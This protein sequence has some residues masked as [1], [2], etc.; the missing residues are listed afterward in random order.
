[1]GDLYGAGL[2]VSQDNGQTYEL[3]NTGLQNLFVGAL[4]AG[5]GSDSVVAG[6]DNGVFLSSGGA[7]WQRP[8]GFAEGVFSLFRHPD[9]SI[10]AGT[11][12]AGVWKSGDGGT[13]WSRASSGIV[14]P[15][16]TGLS[17]TAEGLTAFAATA[18]GPYISRNSGQDW[19]IYQTLGITFS[20]AIDIV[21]PL[22]VFLGGENGKLLYSSDGGQAFALMNK[23]L[24]TDG[25]TWIRVIPFHET[26]LITSAGALYVLDAGKSQWRLLFQRAGAQAYAMDADPRE[27]N[28]L[29]LAT[30]DGVYKSTDA[31]ANW[32]KLAG[33]TGPA[34][35][36]F[37]DIL[38]PGTFYA[39]GL[40]KVAR[41]TDRGESW[42]EFGTGL[43]QGPVTGV[44]KA[45][46]QVLAAVF[47]QGVYRTGAGGD[48]WQ[49][50]PVLPSQ[51][52]T[53]LTSA[54]NEPR[55]ILAG[56]TTDGIFRSTDG[57]A[58]WSRAENGLSL[59]VRGLGGDATGS[60]LYAG[61]LLGGLF[62][63]D[64]GGANWSSAG[65]RD[66]N[67]FDIKAHPVDPN[68]VYAGTSIGI[69][70]STDRGRTWTQVTQ[71][72]ATVTAAAVDPRDRGIIYTG[73]LAGR[74][75]RSLDGGRGWTIANQGL[76]PQS[77]EA[78]TV[79][80]R[81]GT[82]YAALDKSGVFRSRNQGRDW[83]RVS[84]LE[85]VRVLI[86]S[87][88]GVLY[89]GTRANGV[90]QVD[91]TGRW[92]SFAG[93]LPT[94]EIHSLAL[95]MSSPAALLAAHGNGVFRTTDGRNWQ[96]ANR[97]LASGV[98]GL[99]AD[100][101]RPGK[102]YAATSSGLFVTEDSGGRWAAVAG[103]LPRTE[104]TAV[105]VD[106]R[107][108]IVIA[109]GKDGRLWLSSDSGRSWRSSLEGADLAGRA[110][111]FGAGNE[112]LAGSLTRG[113]ARSNDGGAN[114]T[115][116]NAA[117][118]T[119]FACLALAVHPRNPSLVYAG[120]VGPGVLKSIDGG[121][122]W[123]GV[124]GG[125][126]GAQILSLAIDPANPDALFAGTA[127]RGVYATSNGGASWSALGVGIA[128]RTVTALLFDTRNG[129]S[130]YAGTEGGGVFRLD[131]PGR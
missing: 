85:D 66:R 17:I 101:S 89:A 87:P 92:I 33:Y 7:N 107:G 103:G 41:S 121:L 8:T 72:I 80:P 11:E 115:V 122:T 27:P 75:D 40:G 71:R 21:N 19:G 13:T 106:P 59:F 49:K 23:G 111:V 102:L 6:S 125:I 9:G 44:I 2:R 52:V 119:E 131:L 77:V 81:D 82:V 31:G 130:L 39:G 20:S 45:G 126:E 30:F 37:A 3:R 112:I 108:Q 16:I 57:G 18:A 12:R 74:L 29:L 91:E 104:M 51:G 32:S 113:L 38:E 93:N 50:A 26:Y 5:S 116:N 73:G 1:V 68:T 54:L 124:T 65:L 53:V 35:S 22:R 10:Y 56:T 129:R 88:R 94:G 110:I 58:T 24:P 47:D 60:T 4:G 117:S 48:A 118:A 67:I 62:R 76:P 83:E 25:I 43:G 15:N 90:Y 14:P 105:A 46:D 128:R 100:P 55:L 69:S 64:D 109:V 36:M 127:E 34:F 28:V 99:A 84:D 63:S 42:R 95:D 96:P 97:D 120:A 123:T 61:A 70:R 79:D 98:V 86:S 78:I 114:W